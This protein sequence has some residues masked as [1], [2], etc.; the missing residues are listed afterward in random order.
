MVTGK[1]TA[2]PIGTVLRTTILLYDDTPTSEPQTHRHRTDS[3]TGNQ[4]MS[5]D[6]CFLLYLVGQQ[7]YNIGSFPSYIYIY[8]K[9]PYILINTMNVVRSSSLLFR[10]TIQCSSSKLFGTAKSGGRQHQQRGFIATNASNGVGFLGCTS[11]WTTMSAAATTRSVDGSV[12]SPTLPVSQNS[13][14]IVAGQQHQRRGGSLFLFSTEARSNVLDILA[15]EEA[16]E[17]ELGNTALPDELA[18]LKATI[19]QDWRIVEMG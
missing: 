7:K 4:R 1:P 9:S 12:R 3:T 16:E 13:T 10:R 17:H 15:R 14:V 2:T 19:E 8:I 11:N 18:D 5:E 6:R